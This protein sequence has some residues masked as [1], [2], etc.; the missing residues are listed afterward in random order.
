MDLPHPP[1]DGPQPVVP[2]AQHVQFLGEILRHTGGLERNLEVEVF[3]GRFEHEAFVSILLNLY[4]GNARL[5]ALHRFL[6]DLVPHEPALR[7]LTAG[8]PMVPTTSRLP[9]W[10]TLLARKAPAGTVQAPLVTSPAGG[11]SRD[12]ERGHA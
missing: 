9:A 2:L 11:P 1:G 5:A 12:R 6:S 8:L 3:A 4:E 10:H 7:R